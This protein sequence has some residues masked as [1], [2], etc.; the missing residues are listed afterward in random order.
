MKAIV[1][2]KI[3][4]ADMKIF[5]LFVQTLTAHDKYS[6]NRDKLRQPIQMQLTQKKNYFSRFFAAFF[7]FT[8]NFEHFQTIEDPHTLSISEIIDSKR[9]G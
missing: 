1:C 9:R 5:R 3:S 6:L 7:T 2:E 4:L 8:L